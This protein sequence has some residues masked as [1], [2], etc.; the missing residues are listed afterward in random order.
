MKTKISFIIT[1]LMSIVFVWPASAQGIKFSQGSWA[2]LKA[3]AKAENKLIF[4]DFYTTWCIPCKQMA[5]NIFPQKEV[6]DYFNPKFISVQMDAEKEGKALAKEY[7]V[8]AFPTMVFIKPDGKAVYRII[9]SMDANEFIRRSRNAFT[10]NSVFDQLRERFDKGGQLDKKDLFQLT[11]L[12]EDQGDDQNAKKAF[13]Q[14]LSSYAAVDQTTYTMILSHTNSTKDPSF[15]YLMKNRIGFSSLIGKS[16]VDDF[17]KRQYVDELERARSFTV[18]E[19]E[20]EKKKMLGVINL[21][22]KEVL[23]MDANHYWNV[24]NEDHF[25]IVCKVLFDKYIH[26]D[27]QAIGNM[28]GAVSRKIITKPENLLVAKKWAERAYQL[29][30]NAINGMQLA[31]VYKEL[32]DK[33]NA[34]KYADLALAAAKRDHVNYLDKVEVIKKEIEDSF[35]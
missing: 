10:P 22:E 2:E 27:D 18:A 15:K 26:D 25:M 8:K 31:M 34:L 7:D 21:T 1:M 30:D 6:G 3:T 20:L 16:K 29:K 33:E 23:D 32:K 12:F 4:V 24:K 9:G 5:A 19:Y 13:D 17:V 14:Y 28:L 35:N 11:T